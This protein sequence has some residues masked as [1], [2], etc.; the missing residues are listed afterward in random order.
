MIPSEEEFTKHVSG[1]G[2]NNNHHI[3]AYD[4]TGIGS[5]ARVWWMFRLYGHEQISVLNG[6]L[7]AWKKLG[8]VTAGKTSP[9]S[10][11]F[12]AKFNPTL[13]RTLRQMRENVNLK[14][15]QVLDARSQGRFEGIEP[16]PREGLKSGRIPNS[17][18]LPFT[19]IYNPD[20]KFLLDRSRLS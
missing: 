12:V 10:G 8:P 17:H 7:P 13:I 6:G 1:L 4:S 9:T 18:N 20:T 14:S 15:D 19:K 5:A 2:I 16:E 11:D 3:I